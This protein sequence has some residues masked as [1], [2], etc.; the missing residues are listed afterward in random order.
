M[1]TSLGLILPKEMLAHL[2]VEAGQEIF[3]IETPNGY[4]LTALDPKVQK[5][6][7]TGEAFMERHSDVFATMA[8]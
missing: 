4:T 3:A 7:E 1:G 2:H 5:Q 6:I 8:K